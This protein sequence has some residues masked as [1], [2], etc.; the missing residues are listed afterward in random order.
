M[1]EFKRYLTL[2]V[3]ICVCVCVCVCVCIYIYIY[4]YI[5]RERERERE[6]G[7]ISSHRDSH[8]TKNEK[9]NLTNVLKNIYVYK[10]C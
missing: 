4:I 6:R 8:F 2:Y 9:L 3:C 7:E 5:Y 10:N 1:P